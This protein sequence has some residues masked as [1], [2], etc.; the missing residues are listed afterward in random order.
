MTNPSRVFV[1]LSAYEDLTDRE[2]RAL[3]RGDIDFA[4]KLENR[5]LRLAQT[6]GRARK[7]S[8]LSEADVD[9]LSRRVRTLQER[10]TANLEFLRGEMSRVCAE[11]GALDTA[12]NRSRQIRRGYSENNRMAASGNGVLGRA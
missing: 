10:E 5:K 12:T 6:L 2:S 1:I 7:N 9:A 8:V 4:I 3:R 11:L